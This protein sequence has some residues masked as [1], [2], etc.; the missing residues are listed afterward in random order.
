MSKIFKPTLIIAGDIKSIFLEIFFKSLKKKFLK[1]IILLVNKNE[2][3]KQMRMLKYKYNINEIKED[4]NLAEKYNLKKLNFI[5]IKKKDEK[6]Y[7]NKCFK[8]FFKLLKKNSNINLINGPINK[9]KFL[10]KKFPGITEFIADKFS[11]QN[12]V[13]MLIFNKQLSVSPLTTH[14]PLKDVSKNIS[15]K[16]IINHV[17]LIDNFYKK[18]F[19]IIPKI[20]ITG[21]NPHCESNFNNSED[22]KIITPAIKKLLKFK[23]NVHGPFPADTIFLKQNYRKFNVIIGMY[24]DQVLTPL[25]AIY[26]FNAINITLGLPIIRISPDHGPNVSMFGK[27][28]SNPNSLIM[29]LKFFE[30]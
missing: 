23:Y 11:K 24:H 12:E 5:N 15:E 20:A 30:N 29:A 27:N 26:D 2:L 6:S 21:L 17:K 13:V 19:K 7:I 3:I 16:K 18:K 1:P 10:N 8:T 9:S 25:K 28:K 4:D 22:K 14:I